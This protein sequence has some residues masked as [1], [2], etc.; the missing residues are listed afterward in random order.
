MVINRVEVSRDIELESI[1]ELAFEFSR[2]ATKVMVTGSW[3]RDL[4]LDK[5]VSKDPAGLGGSVTQGITVSVDD[6]VEKELS[7]RIKLNGGRI[8]PLLSLKGLQIL[9]DRNR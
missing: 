6:V 2:G 8:D 3:G 4:P 1:L 7:D 9:F 5:V